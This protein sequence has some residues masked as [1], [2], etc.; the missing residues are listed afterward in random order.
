MI[1]ALSWVAG[2]LVLVSNW[3]KGNKDI[4][5]W[6]LALLGNVLFL[7][8]NFEARLYGLCPLA[9]INAYLCLRAI[10]LWK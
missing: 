5:G 9:A 10:R 2:I 1:T 3:A 6:Y 4:R 7:Y 8:L